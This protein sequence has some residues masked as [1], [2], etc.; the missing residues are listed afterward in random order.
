MNSLKHP[1]I[2]LIGRSSFNFVRQHHYYLHCS[3]SL[4]LRSIYLGRVFVDLR[5]QLWPVCPG[6][7]LH[8]GLRVVRLLHLLVLFP[9]VVAPFVHLGVA[10]AQGLRQAPDVFRLPVRV[11]LILILQRVDLFRVEAPPNQLFGLRLL[12]AVFVV[13]TGE[14]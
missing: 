8:H 2:L 13:E 10:D 12:L 7:L 14:F 11:L 6:R 9:S 4:V 3:D 5:L 1:H